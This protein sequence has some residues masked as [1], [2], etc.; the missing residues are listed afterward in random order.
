VTD[1]RGHAGRDDGRREQLHQHP[2][3][4]Q[5][6]RDQDDQRDQ[7]YRAAVERSRQP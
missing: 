4:L 3:D 1:H 6:E 5:P 7:A 2:F